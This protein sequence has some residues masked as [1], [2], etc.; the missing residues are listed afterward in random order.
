MRLCESFKKKKIILLR[1]KLWC[2]CRIQDIAWE[3]KNR[4]RDFNQR[5]YTFSLKLK[6]YLLS[7]VLNHVSSQCSC[8]VNLDCKS[9]SWDHM[10]INIDQLDFSHQYWSSWSLLSIL[11]TIEIHDKCFIKS[12]YLL[13]RSVLLQ[14]AWNYLYFCKLIRYFHLYIFNFQEKDEQ[15]WVIIFFTQSNNFV[16][17]NHFLTKKSEW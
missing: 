3:R 6:L 8:V 2:L 5:L 9:W 17:F 1:A 14:L 11:I 16:V 15:L 10:I 4:M 13:M 7:R 12:S